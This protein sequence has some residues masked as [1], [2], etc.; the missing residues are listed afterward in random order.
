MGLKVNKLMKDVKRNGE[1]SE[2]GPRGLRGTD[3]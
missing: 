3:S 1:E 2:E